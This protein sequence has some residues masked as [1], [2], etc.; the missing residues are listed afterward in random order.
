MKRQMN[1]GLMAGFGVLAVA[2]AIGCEAQVDD[3]YTGEALFS[4]Q[5][6]VV[7]SKDQTYPNV[8][9]AIAFPR[10]ENDTMVIIDGELDGEFPAKFRFDV[11]QP[12]PEEVLNDGTSFGLEGKAA[13]GLLVLTP[14]NL[15]RPIVEQLNVSSEGY[16]SE[17][18]TE[19]TE[20]E[21]QCTDDGR[22]RER[23]LECTERPCELVEQW[24][25]MAVVDPDSYSFDDR[26]DSETCYEMETACDAENRCRTNVYRCDFGQYGTY[27]SIV[28]GS[29]ANCTVQSTG[30]D[31]SLLAMEDLQVASHYWIIYVT[32]ASPNSF[33]GPLER[34]YNLVAFPS[35]YD[36]WIES[37]KC[38]EAKVAT[39][40]AE[41]N[42]EHGTSHDPLGFE[43]DF[44]VTTEAKLACGSFR[45]IDRP[46]D[47]VLTIE[48][49]LIAPIDF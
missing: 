27:A 38:V 6:N 41:Y 15:D 36:E 39:A 14:S 10:S 31:T 18:G 47:E 11:T 20:V 3:D 19:C 1:L 5:G 21:R 25:D 12:P 24:G 30:G 35:S 34:G 17:D 7:V 32:E 23:V 16:C 13:L 43:L 42:E 22:C 37:R 44:S 33:W 49:G 9:P 29:M 45:V 48:M 26:C 40:V 4:L 8:V 28:G 46:L 2:S